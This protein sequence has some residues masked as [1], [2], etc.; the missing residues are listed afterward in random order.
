[1]T[2][3]NLLMQRGRAATVMALTY[4]QT[5]K[6]RRNVVINKSIDYSDAV[7]VSPVSAAPT[8]SSFLDLTPGFDR[9]DRDNCTETRKFKCCDS[10]R[11]ILEVSHDIPVTASEVL[12]Q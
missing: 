12:D 6:I 2:A 10:V 5:S 4:L 3:N 9:L 1:M 11:L 7:G 8:T